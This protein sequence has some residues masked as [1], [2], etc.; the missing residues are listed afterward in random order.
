MELLF[1]LALTVGIFAGIWAYTST[2]INIPTWIAFLSWAVFYAAGGKQEGIKKGLPSCLMGVFWAWLAVTIWSKIAPQNIPVLCLIVSVLSFILVYQSRIKSLFSFAPG[3][4][5]GAATFFGATGSGASIPQVIGGLVCGLLLGFIQ[6]NVALVLAKKEEKLPSSTGH[7]KD[8]DDLEGK[9]AQF[10]A[11]LKETEGQR[12]SYEEA[13]DD[14]EAE[15]ATVAQARDN[16]QHKV[17]ELI[18]SNN[19]LQKQVDELTTQLQ[20]QMETVGPLFRKD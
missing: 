12:D 7:A 5:V 18:T 3:A 1:S 15:L 19:E 16:L 2:L 8:Q 11:V 17:N 14:A 6:Q 9:L 10:E 13:F 4:F 20:E